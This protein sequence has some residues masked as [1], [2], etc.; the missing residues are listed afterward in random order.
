MRMSRRLSPPGIRSTKGRGNCRSTA[1]VGNVYNIGRLDATRPPPP[2][3]GRI[4]EAAG[5]GTVSLSLAC[6]SESLMISNASITLRQLKF[7]STRPPLPHKPPLVKL[8]LGSKMKNLLCRPVRSFNWSRTDHEKW[9][10]LAAG[11]PTDGFNTI[12][13]AKVR[14][15]ADVQASAMQDTTTH[16]RACLTCLHTNHCYDTDTCLRLLQH[17]DLATPVYNM[18]W[19]SQHA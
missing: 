15:D 4:V 10:M 17:K 3:S 5:R 12:H 11:R 14:P 6:F 16:V 18:H 7:G 13:F 1:Q 8:R 9:P 19:S 2:L